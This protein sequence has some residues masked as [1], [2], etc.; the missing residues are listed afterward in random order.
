MIL[1]IHMCCMKVHPIHMCTTK[2]IFSSIIFMRNKNH[3][4]RMHSQRL[5]LIRPRTYRNKACVRIFKF[6]DMS[7]SWDPVSN[8]QFAI[9]FL[10]VYIFQ[11]H[12]V[13]YS[14]VVVTWIIKMSSG[15]KPSLFQRRNWTIPILE[16]SCCK[17]R[18]KDSQLRN[19]FW[20]TGDVWRFWMI[21]NW[22]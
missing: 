14:L 8:S 7:G 11:E 16:P 13:F 3:G 9:Y 15:Q 1:L 20:G 17:K 10:F 22:S 2:P 6:V 19:W 5:C 12:K 4:L 21:P 18:Q